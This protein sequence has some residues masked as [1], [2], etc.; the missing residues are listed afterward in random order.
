MK[1][2]MNTV[3][4]SLKALHI[5]LI[6]LGAFSLTTGCASGGASYEK[7][8]FC[9]TSDFYV[10]PESRMVVIEKPLQEVER[11]LLKWILLH[12]GELLTNTK[13]EAQAVAVNE[14]GGV[15]FRI[16]R[17]IAEKAWA[18]YTANDFSMSIAPEEFNRMK[19]SML[20]TTTAVDRPAVIAIR[21]LFS[22]KSREVSFVRETGEY[23]W[24]K[25]FTVGLLLP[26]SVVFT[27]KEKV[28]VIIKSQL[29]FLLF[30][31]DGKTHVYATGRPFE[32]GS[33]VAAGYGNSIGYDWWHLVTGKEEAQLVMLVLKAVTSTEASSVQP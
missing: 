25:N 9:W 32:S 24:V 8:D 11:T 18:S 22:D 26:P 14:D 7:I 31:M 3:K 2:T 19:D 6:L 12:H 4:H 5:T 15:N 33:G 27:K 29:D 21:A 13:G 23:D 17:G 10:E 28:N 30:D 20:A 1:W 16:A